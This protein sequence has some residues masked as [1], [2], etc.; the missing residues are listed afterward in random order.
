MS[1]RPHKRKRATSLKGKCVEYIGD[2]LHKVFEASVLDLKLRE[3]I[4]EYLCE[5]P[6][7]V[8]LP[9]G[10][11][12]PRLRVACALSCPMRPR[13]LTALVPFFHSRPG[14]A[15]QR[16]R[17]PQCVSAQQAAAGPGAGPLALV[18]RSIPWL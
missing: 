2:N 15:G 8:E 4:L 11:A 13:L 1:Y 3:Q 7:L 10:A 14:P 17:T 16:T 9:D 5:T 18:G 12:R 6:I